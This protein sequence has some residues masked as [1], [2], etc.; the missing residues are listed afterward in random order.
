VY[1]HIHAI[2][3]VSSNFMCCHTDNEQRPRPDLPASN[4]REVAVR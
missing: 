2:G 4:R 1:E 3:E